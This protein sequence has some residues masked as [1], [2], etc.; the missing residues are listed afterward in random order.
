MFTVFKLV[1]PQFLLNIS[2]NRIK[3][4]ISLCVM[5]ARLGPG[6]TEYQ[7]CSDRNAKE[8][9][10]MVSCVVTAHRHAPSP[11]GKRTLVLHAHRHSSRIHQ[12][13]FS[14]PTAATH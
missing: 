8:P 1:V 7:T 3:T 5:C 4:H 10:S 14:H 12:P 11:F 9:C 2:P 6:S 13:Y